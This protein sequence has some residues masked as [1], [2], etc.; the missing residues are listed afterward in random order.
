MAE[1]GF[2]MPADVGFDLVPVPVVIAIFLPEEQMGSSAASVVFS[3]RARNRLSRYSSKAI[4]EGLRLVRVFDVQITVSAEPE[5][6]STGL[7]FHL[8]PGGQC[9]HFF[10]DFHQSVTIDSLDGHGIGNIIDDVIRP[11]TFYRPFSNLCFMQR[12]IVLR[13]PPAN[14]FFQCLQCDF[15]FQ[16][17]PPFLVA[18]IMLTLAY[19]DG[20]VRK[21]KSK[22]TLGSAL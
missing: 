6:L 17:P 22:S 2:G 12:L 11:Q 18:V 5:S 21:K 10:T 19:L 1:F 13:Q 15:G 9:V 4:S 16:W 14:S 8:F 7:F 20:C 3:S